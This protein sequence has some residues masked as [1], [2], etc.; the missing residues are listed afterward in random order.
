MQA[1]AI[2]RAVLGAGALGLVV[3]LVSWFWPGRRGGGGAW[4]LEAVERPWRGGPSIHDHIR[5][6]IAPGRPGLTEGGEELP[7]ER[8]DGELRWVAGGMDGAFGHHG[9]GGGDARRARKLHGALRAVLRDLSPAA[10]KRFYEL[11]LDGSAIDAMDPLLDRAAERQDLAADRLGE[12]ARWIARNA[13]DREPVK[14]ALALLGAAG[15]PEDIE[16]VTTLGR[17]EELTLYAAVALMKIGGDRAE[18]LLFHLA[19]QVTGWGRIHLVERLA[20][21][22]SS[23]IQ[24]WML[25]EGYRNDVMVEY[26]AHVCATTGGLRLALEADEIDP[27]LLTG[28]GELLAALIAGGPAED[29]D[30]YDDGAA[31]VDRYLHHLGA[32]PRQ[33]DQLV[34]VDQIGRFLEG[35]GDWAARASRDWTPARREALRARTRE[36]IALPY[37]PGA[38]RAGLASGDPQTFHTA[39]RAAA[40]LGI[41]T[42]D[43]QFARLEAGEDDAWFAVMQTDDPARIDR[44]VAHA[45][46]A[47][48][49]EDIATG[50]AEELGLGAAWRQHSSLDFV[51]QDLRRFPGKGWPLLRAGLQSPVVRNRNMALRALSA[52]GRSAWPPDAE[53]ILIQARGREP[54][55][56][57]RR[58]IEA[59]LAG[60]PLE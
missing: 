28:A 58:T 23:A 4:N 31:V 44:V 41:D 11:L 32:E 46:R 27:A 33:L 56:E 14:V 52:W 9:G 26:L 30:D 40:I 22:G 57:V 37:W 8:D 20:G 39:A 47:L 54:D 16:L 43:H 51:L 3:A 19:Q 13:P 10:L 18:E 5:A 35:D 29:M 2:V 1:N 53:P 25:R 45:E 50:P 17:H 38:V 6:H 60:T 42:W 12:L 34:I 36:I 55:P 48:P 15:G 21:T 49:L 24:A 7:D 59:V